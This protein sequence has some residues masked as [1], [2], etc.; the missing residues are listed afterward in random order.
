MQDTVGRSIATSLITHGDWS[1]EV[2]CYIPE[3]AVTMQP[4]AHGSDAYQTAISN[5]DPRLLE[6]VLTSFVETRPHGLRFKADDPALL[7]VKL[8]EAQ[9]QKRLGRLVVL[10]QHRPGAPWQVSDEVVQLSADG[11]RAT[12]PILS[13]CA[14]AVVDG[15]AAGVLLPQRSSA[16]ATVFADGSL[17]APELSMHDLDCLDDLHLPE[18]TEVSAPE[19]AF[20]SAIDDGQPPMAVSGA[21]EPGPEPEPESAAS[22]PQQVARVPRGPSRSGAFFSAYAPPRLQPNGDIFLVEV[23]AYTKAFMAEVTQEVQ[24]GSVSKGKKGPLK[25][26][27]G[28]AVS[29]ALTLPAEVFDTDELAPDEFLWEGEYGIAQ[30]M[31]RCRRAAP[32]GEHV[33]TA[34]ITVDGRRTASLR[35][36]LSVVARELASPP[37]SPPNERVELAAELALDPP[38]GLPPRDSYRGFSNTDD[39]AQVY[40]ANVVHIISAP[41]YKANPVSGEKAAATKLFHDHAE[42]GCTPSTQIVG[43][44]RRPRRSK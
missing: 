28:A 20:V 17:P 24:P 9:R 5:L 23:A 44:G 36:K 6:H 39:F 31:A 7:Q 1:L 32:L 34:A 22:R 8:S 33:C 35:F 3:D 16:A 40:A 43:C 25:L 11:Q 37:V 41:Y 30:F 12:I 4:V 13:F 38:E 10:H 26:R 29:V 14:R 42:E 18:W 19:P 27:H 15:D 2:P 21:L